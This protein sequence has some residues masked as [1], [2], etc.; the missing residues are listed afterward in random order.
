[1]TVLD[2]VLADLTAE[3][4]QLDGWVADLD[5]D[6]DAGGWATVTTAEGWTVSASD[7]PPALDR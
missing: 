7:R 2:D 5:P 1:M 3:S 4:E 6:S